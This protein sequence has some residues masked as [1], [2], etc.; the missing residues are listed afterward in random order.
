MPHAIDDLIGTLLAGRLQR[1]KLGLSDSPR[2]WPMQREN[3]CRRLAG[4]PG[5]QDRD[6]GLLFCVSPICPATRSAPLGARPFSLKN[7]QANAGRC[8]TRAK[9]VSLRLAL[10]RERY[11]AP[12]E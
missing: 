7:L 1:P 6:A 5:Q 12:V 11:R 2:F 8:D 9:S 10:G 3:G 4:L